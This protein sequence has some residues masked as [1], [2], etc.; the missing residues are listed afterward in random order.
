MTDP[1]SLLLAA[2][3]RQVEQKLTSQQRERQALQDKMEYVTR[4][5]AAQNELRKLRSRKRK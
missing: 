1:F 4:L 3:D 2:Y 5:N